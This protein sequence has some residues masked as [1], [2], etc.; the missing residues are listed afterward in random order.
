MTDDEIEEMRGK[1][2]GYA[3]KL[4]GDPWAAEDLVH[5]AFTRC[6][7]RYGRLESPVLYATI[8]NLWI[9]ETRRRQRRHVSLFEFDELAVIGDPHDGVRDRDVLLVLGTL[10]ARHSTVLLDLYVAGRSM[11]EVAAR[12]GIT[13]SGVKGLSGRAKRCFLKAWMEAA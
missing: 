13:R 3:W 12:E 9:D 7:A 4:C 8:R 6:L 1:L 11:D 5:D 10:T 2:V